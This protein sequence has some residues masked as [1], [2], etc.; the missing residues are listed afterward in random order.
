MSGPVAS[1]VR[2]S[3]NHDSLAMRTPHGALIANVL[4]FIF[5][6]TAAFS[7]NHLSFDRITMDDGLSN[8]SVIAMCQDVTGAMWFGT[9][10]GAERYDGVGFRTFNLGG[11]YAMCPDDRGYVWIG[12]G[13]NGLHCYDIA[14]DTLISISGTVDDPNP[15]AHK[16]I[17]SLLLD[18]EG[19]LWIGLNHGVARFDTK[20]RKYLE[21]LRPTSQRYG[22]SS[23]VDDHAGNMWLGFCCGIAKLEQ[24][25]GRSTVY[26][27]DLSSTS[28]VNI[29]FGRDGRLWMNGGHVAGLVC[30]DTTRHTWSRYGPLGA[31]FNAANVLVDDNGRV[32]VTTAGDGLRIFDPTSGRWEDYHHHSSDPQSLTS[33]R[34]GVIYR[35][36]VGNIWFGTRNGVSR[37]ARW[38]KQFWSIPHNTDNPNSPP[39]TPIRSISED[40]SGNLWIGSYGGGVRMWDRRANTFTTIEGIGPF[41]H[42]VLAARSGWIWIGTEN[43]NAVTAIEPKTKRKK[44]FTFSMKDTLTIPYGPVYSLF[45]DNDGSIWVGNTAFGIGRIDPSTGKCRRAKQLVPAWSSIRGFYRDREG[46]LWAPVNDMLVEVFGKADSSR[47]LS[48]QGHLNFW[49]RPVNAVYEDQKGRFWVGTHGGFGLMDR[50]TGNLTYV[51]HDTMMMQVSATYGILEDGNHDLWLL[52]PKGVSRFRPDTREFTNFGHENGFPYTNL[53]I[54]VVRGTTSYCRTRNGFLVFGTGEGIVI[55]HPDSIHNNPIRPNVIMTEMTIAGKPTRL[56]LTAWSA[57]EAFEYRPIELL[58]D[59]NSIAFEFAALD[60][61]DAQ[62]NAYSY[63]LEGLE[64]EW[65]LAKPKRRAEYP[66][67]SPGNY[68]F[69]VKASN[70]D[71]VWNEQGALVRITVLPPWW[72]TWWFRV[73]MALGVLGLI[74]LVMQIRIKRAVAQ[75]RLRLQ[76]ASDLHDDIGSSLSSIALVSENVRDVLGDGHPVVSDLDSV[77]STARQAA[78]RLRDAVWAIKPGSDSLENLVLRMKDVTHSVIGHLQHTFTSDADGAARLVPLEFR[79]NVLLIYKEALHNILKHSCAANVAVTIHLTDGTF[80]LDV[81]DDGKGF[82]GKE[83]PGGNGLASMK[84]RAEAL[85]GTLSIAS[86]CNQGTHIHLVAK[87]PRT[88]Y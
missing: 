48:V 6:C 18:R 30:F 41:V 82:D 63:M 37:F 79:R 88:R 70:N 32:W 36:K 66:G 77:T 43:P 21:D 5:S 84:R 14:N 19:I 81:R 62:Q 74:Y 72:M 80:T 57:N 75:E 78:D 44:V 8:P 17:S 64:N 35:D 85:G 68:A 9:D 38:R 54:N 40:R 13:Q 52:N 27:Y 69:R 50:S 25:T 71:G 11:V 12:A 49:E 56:H 86:N 87:I 65:S 61:T 28:K 46:R 29:T 4:L 42:V 33:D 59:Q 26:D 47:G 10:D 39:Q 58:Y 31:S 2:S 22:I 7:Q 1:D 83:C 76:I 15:E 23:I 3:D 67:L 45:E 51:R 73:L 20:Q 53:A 24:A 16:S 55:F 60:F 34:I